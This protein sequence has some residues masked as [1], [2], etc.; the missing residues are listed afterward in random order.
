[1]LDLHGVGI[2]Y[3]RVLADAEAAFA[4]EQKALKAKLKKQKENEKK[5]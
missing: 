1:M 4:K 2:D 5:R 3:S